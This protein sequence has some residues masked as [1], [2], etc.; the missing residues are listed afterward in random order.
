MCQLAQFLRT[1]GSSQ[2]RCQCVFR[3]AH[4]KK[5]R[6]QVNFSSGRKHKELKEKG[7]KEEAVSAPNAG[8]TCRPRSPV[9]AAGGRGR[10]PL[11]HSAPDLSEETTKS[12]SLHLLFTATDGTNIW[13][14]TSLQSFIRFAYHAHPNTLKESPSKRKLLLGRRKF[15]SVLVN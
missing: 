3:V 5:Q 1:P 7:V 15:N 8:G 2:G 10:Q 12:H 6:C 11:P 13:Q 9:P 14:V 4:R